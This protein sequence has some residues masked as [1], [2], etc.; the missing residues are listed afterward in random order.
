MYLSVFPNPCDF[1]ETEIEKMLQQSHRYDISISAGEMFGFETS[2]TM[3]RQKEACFIDN[4]ENSSFFFK[5]SFGYCAIS[6]KSYKS[7]KLTSIQLI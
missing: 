3:D 1:S 4:D 7:L 5:C 2:C 6:P